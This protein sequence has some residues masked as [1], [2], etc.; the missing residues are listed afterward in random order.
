M[1]GA[2]PRFCQFRLRREQESWPPG[3]ASR[4]SIL[5]LIYFLSTGD[6]WSIWTVVA[7]KQVAGTGT[8]LAMP[9]RRQPAGSLR[10]LANRD[11]VDVF[12]QAAAAIRVPQFA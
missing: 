11:L 7:R 5:P 1:P 9:E 10:G 3:R 12:A 4:Y 6:A 8:A 2:F